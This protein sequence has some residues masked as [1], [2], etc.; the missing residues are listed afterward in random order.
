MGWGFEGGSVVRVRV[1]ARV[2]Q[3][4]VRVRVRVVQVRVKVRTRVVQVMVIKVSP[5]QH[6]P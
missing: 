2:V 6:L 4:W 1:R 3:V 5:T